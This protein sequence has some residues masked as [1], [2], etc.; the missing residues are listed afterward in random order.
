MIGAA[1]AAVGAIIA[2][3]L[4]PNRD[5]ELESEDAKFRAYLAEHGF[6]TE[7]GETLEQELKS[8]AFKV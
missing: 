3:T 6:S 8:T 7:F 2:Y 1:F 5:R 4:I